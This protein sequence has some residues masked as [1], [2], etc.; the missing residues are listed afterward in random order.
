MLHREEPDG[1]VVITQP[2]HAWISGQLA[3]AWGADRFP[4]PE[5]REEVCLA[6][7]QHDNGWTAWEQAPT[8][9]PKTGRPYAFLEMP[10]AEHVAIWSGAARWSAVLSRYAALL[11]ALHGT[12]LY[13]KY[14]TPGGS[15]EEDELVGRFLVQQEELQSGLLSSLR[16]DPYYAPYAA[17]EKVAINRRLVGLW[18]G[19]SLAIC[20]GVRKPRSLPTVYAADRTE[21]LYLSPVDGDPTRL[22]VEPWPFVEPE[23]TLVCEGRRLLETFDDQEAMRAALAAAPCVVLTTTLTPQ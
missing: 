20:H 10:V 18:D 23:V 7:E 9:N 21:E 13:R 15:P 16:R 6:A 17:D 22:V 14:Y 1:L 3:R 11:V 4:P 8:L 12:G 5:P 2:A 19:M